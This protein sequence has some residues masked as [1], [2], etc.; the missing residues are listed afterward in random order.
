MNIFIQNYLYFKIFQTGNQLPSV[1]ADI[2]E[3]SVMD[4][5]EEQTAGS[6]FC[7]K[8]GLIAVD[9]A[10]GDWSPW[11]YCSKTCGG[12]ERTRTRLCNSPSPSEGGADCLGEDSELL[13]CNTEPCK[14]ISFMIHCVKTSMFRSRGWRLVYMVYLVIMH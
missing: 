5:I 14:I 11:S 12:G 9:G 7:T 8:S 3:K 13:G 2:R 6:T 10:W 4:W 1:Y